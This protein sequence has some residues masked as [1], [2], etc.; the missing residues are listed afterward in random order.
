MSKPLVTVLMPVFNSGDFLE[1]A[2]NSILRQSFSDFELLIID[3]G[4][5][6]S[7]PAILAKLSKK[8]KRIRVVTHK[9]NQGLVKTLNEGLELARGE[10]IARMDSDDIA[11]PT[12]LSK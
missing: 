1:E 9:K 4:S 8:D 10:F 5:N 3:D 2:L 12:R 6:D 7:S 11:L